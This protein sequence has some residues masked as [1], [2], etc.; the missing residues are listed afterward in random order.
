MDISLDEK[1]IQGNTDGISKAMLTRI[2]GMY[3]MGLPRDIFISEE[4][5]Q[6]MAYCS[7]AVHR[8]ISVLVS[9]GG[10]VENIS[11]GVS[12]RA[13]I[14]KLAAKRSALRLSGIRC[15]HT[16][17]NGSG[18]LSDVDFS[19]L[20]DGR[21]DAMAAIGV[22]DGKA[23]EMYAAFLTGDHM[24][25]HTLG[26]FAPSAFGEPELMR[27]IADSD[28][29]LGRA[30]VH[31]LTKTREFAMLIGLGDEGLDEL[32]EL[33]LTAGAKV[34]S[35]EIQNR[36]VP[37]RVTYIGRGKVEDLKQRISDLDIDLLIVNADITPIQQS[38]LEDALGIKIVD[39]TALI[40][41]IFAMRARSKEGC[42][43][44]ELAQM[45]YLL[46]RL[47]GKGIA[48]S[49]QGGTA[50]GGGIASRGP[51]ETKLE[52]DRRHIR[53]RIH[54]L[55]E[56]IKQLEKQRAYRR[57]RRAGSGIPS[58]ALVGY[59]NAGKSTLLNALTG[60][61]AYVEDKLFATLDPLT[62]RVDI[63]GKEMVITDTVGFVKNLP[64]DL[65]T[66]FRSTLEEVTRA[67]ILL[68][69]VDGSNPEMS[70]QIN[71]VK[72]VLNSLDS[73]DKPTIIAFNKTDLTDAPAP[74]TMTAVSASTGQ[75]I[76]TLKQVIC[77]M[78][79]KM[80]RRHSLHV[81]YSRSD[82]VSILHK[83]GTVFSEE[84]RDEEMVF[85]VELPDPVYNQ[86]K[87]A[88]ST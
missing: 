13:E 34:V 39:R 32:K 72:E 33:A 70:G 54:A 45:K 22:R 71:V 16:H 4:L 79:S 60:A 77:E 88:V 41:D 5:A 15:I 23:I 9:R 66:A 86:I 24:Q 20:N 11:V 43:Q 58:I 76:D 49:R 42:L 53:R 40:L 21:L 82:I 75:G 25:Y 84:Y 69:V 27:A 80:W 37:D 48:L 61:D 3:D 18:R 63:A 78:L 50:G 65:V 28:R 31:D 38:N 51:G 64:H 19:A 57:S 62:R 81:P 10:T 74:K 29:D 73:G 14:P 17:P 44:V 87:E 12:D 26:P 56:E 7:S 35:V 68:H 52:L 8:E 6:L 59:T 30:Q 85:E 2:Q 47:I 55:E 1:Q 36:A 46:P 67:D 83:S